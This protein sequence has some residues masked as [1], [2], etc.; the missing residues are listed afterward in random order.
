MISV[1]GA[2]FH[3]RVQ[4]D[5]SCANHFQPL[6]RHGYHLACDFESAAAIASTG[7][8]TGTGTGRMIDRSPRPPP[9]PQGE[10]GI[11]NLR[12]ATVLLVPVG[13][14]LAGMERATGHGPCCRL[15]SR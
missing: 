3:S 5:A 2:R 14:R 1:V 4:A 8:G 15:G 11:I 10:R 12:T 9:L 6:P 7:T 13:Y